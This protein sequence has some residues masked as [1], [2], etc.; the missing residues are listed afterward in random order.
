M[1]S[2]SESRI[3]SLLDRCIPCVTGRP[4]FNDDTGFGGP[5]ATAAGVTAGEVDV[6]GVL[7]ASN[8]TRA[9]L[10]GGSAGDPLRSPLMESSL[11]LRVISWATV[12]LRGGEAISFLT[13]CF[14]LSSGKS[15]NCSFDSTQTHLHDPGHIL[16]RCRSL[17]FHFHLFEVWYWSRRWFR[18]DRFRGGFRLLLQRTRRFVV[19]IIGVD[20]LRRWFSYKG[21]KVFGLAVVVG[22]VWVIV[23]LCSLG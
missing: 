13:S 9:R 8:S 3:I 6:D 12:F 20:F 21:V 10:T 18:R 17:H 16:G 15:L 19:D 7:L 1:A 5:L 22:N 4:Q 14:D 11:F 23:G 2:S